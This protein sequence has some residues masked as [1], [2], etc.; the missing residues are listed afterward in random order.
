MNR[1]LPE[2]LERYGSDGRAIA[3][4][5]CDA[6]RARL[7]ARAAREVT[8]RKTLLD[9]SSLPGKLA[10]CSSRD[11]KESELF[12]VE[13]DSAAGPAIKARDSVT[14]AI[15]P[16]RGKIINVEKARLARALQNEEV[17]A[18][19]TAVGT[20][21][22]EEFDIDKARYHRIVLLTD[23]DVDGAHIRTLLLTLLFRHLRGL[24][25]AGYVYV[26]Q[27]P[28]YRVKVGKDVVYLTDDAA[29]AVFRQESKHQGVKPTRFKGLGE[30]NAPE[31]WETSMNPETRRLLRVELDDAAQAAETF[32]VLMGDDVA[33]RKEF[34]QQNARDVR[35]LDI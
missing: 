26:A 2:W 30:M 14:Q 13:G 18:I 27:P 4:K 24:I 17:Q 28:L 7:A 1:L 20:G 8:R 3:Q 23:A 32:T 21:L 29:L 33:A 16:I 6:A 34:I 22:G 25:E 15:L 9:S 31:L 19:I 12:I 11:P 10:D 5:S 35:F